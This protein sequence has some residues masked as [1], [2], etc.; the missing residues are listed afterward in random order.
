MNTQAVKA[1]VAREYPI[2]D[3]IKVFMEKSVAKATNSID[4]VKRLQVADFLCVRAE[5][6]AFQEVD[7]RGWAETNK[8][9]AEIR[10]IHKDV[11][12]LLAGLTINTEIT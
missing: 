3:Q 8:A 9:I 4:L 10:S 6:I 11:K 12:E 2:E 1:Q 5:A 7:V